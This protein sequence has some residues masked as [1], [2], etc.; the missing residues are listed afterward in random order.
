MISCCNVAAA[1]CDN[2][3]KE[4]LREAIIAV[5]GNFENV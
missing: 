1:R 4:C 2:V 5:R 3:M